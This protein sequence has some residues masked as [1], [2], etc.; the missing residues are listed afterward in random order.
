[1]HF[2]TKWKFSTEN[3]RRL[4]KLGKTHNKKDKSPGIL[5]NSFSAGDKK[6][7]LLSKKPYMAKLIYEKEKKNLH[8]DLLIKTSLEK[9]KIT[10]L[11]KITQEIENI[12]KKIGAQ[13]ITTRTW[14][15]VVHPKLM[16]ILGFEP[17]NWEDYEDAKQKMK[18][19]AGVISLRGKYSYLPLVKTKKGTIEHRPVPLVEFHKE[20]HKEIPSSET[21]QK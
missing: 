13:E 15:F 21:T 5:V 1:M 9:D 4:K 6:V 7:F 12:A 20:I 8:W 3:E 18:D 17:D 19:V 14:I 11:I 10:T 2:H 16:K